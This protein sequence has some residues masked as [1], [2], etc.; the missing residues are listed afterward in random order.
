MCSFKS[1]KVNLNH[2]LRSLCLLSHA[3][4]IVGQNVYWKYFKFASIVAILVGTNSVYAL[5][6]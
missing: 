6:V 5:R 2:L 1:F 3:Q 4:I